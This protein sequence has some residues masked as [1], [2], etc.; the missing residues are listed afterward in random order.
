MTKS[1]EKVRIKK[2]RVIGGIICLALALLLTILTFALPEERLMFMI[3]DDN[4]P[5]VPAIL[6]G[7]IV[8]TLLANEKESHD[9]EFTGTAMEFS[10]TT[11]QD[12][13][14][15]RLNKRLERMG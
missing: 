3:G 15:I 1:R 12:P 13:E 5:I 6:L 10:P 8:I 4:V 9:E 11:A 7:N 14:K 2:G